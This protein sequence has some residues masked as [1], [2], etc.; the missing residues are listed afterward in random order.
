MVTKN[1]WRDIETEQAAW[2]PLTRTTLGDTNLLLNGFR[3]KSTLARS[4]GLMTQGSGSMSPQSKLKVGLG[5][6]ENW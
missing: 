3:H 2:K 6:H 4:T 5:L 1:G